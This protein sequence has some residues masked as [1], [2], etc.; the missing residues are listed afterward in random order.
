MRPC[1]SNVHQN[2][3]KATGLESLGHRSQLLEGNRV[4]GL[5]LYRDRC[6]FGCRRVQWEVWNLRYRH[7]DT[8]FYDVL[9]SPVLNDP[10]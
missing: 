1:A 7:R 3:K 6:R 2:K 9:F 5:L 10:E 8:D 4:T